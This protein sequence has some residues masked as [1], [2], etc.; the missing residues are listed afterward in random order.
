MVVVPEFRPAENPRGCFGGATLN[1][2]QTFG[3]P[4]TQSQTVKIHQF[5][6]IRLTAH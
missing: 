6:A 3:D 2:R 4:G 1:R 5:F